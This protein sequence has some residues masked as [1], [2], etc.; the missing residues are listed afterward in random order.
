MN[1]VENMSFRLNLSVLAASRIFFLSSLHSGQF[2]DIS[3]GHS[4]IHNLSNQETSI[5]YILQEA[6]KNK[7]SENLWNSISNSLVLQVETIILRFTRFFGMY[8]KH[9]LL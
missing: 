8:M 4:A 1:I 7:N 5:A 3:S 2:Q 6:F 9:A